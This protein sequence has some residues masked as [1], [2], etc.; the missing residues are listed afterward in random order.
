MCT[1]ASPAPPLLLHDVQHKTTVGLVVLV[2]K[3][4][5][6]NESRGGIGVYVTPL[7]YGM[8]GLHA[9]EVTQLVISSGAVSVRV[10][11]VQ[12]SPYP[13]VPRARQGPSPPSVAR[14][15]GDPPGVS[16]GNPRT[17]QLPGT[18][19]PRLHRYT[20]TH[21]PTVP[22]PAHPQHGA[23]STGNPRTRQPGP[24]NCA[25]TQ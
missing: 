3:L 2:C 14:A 20:V 11:R 5:S 22:H 15:H 21:A 19:S 17:W 1:C 23:H 10:V 4:A 13:R 7:P 9:G 12:V 24:R 6:L 16:H 25:A 18:W 8:R